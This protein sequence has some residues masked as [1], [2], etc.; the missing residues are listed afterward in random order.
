MAEEK[1]KST[2]SCGLDPICHAKKFL[3]E[4]SK[5]RHET[6]EKVVDDAERGYEEEET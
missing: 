1:A 3:D 6:I 2:K 5:S 4:A